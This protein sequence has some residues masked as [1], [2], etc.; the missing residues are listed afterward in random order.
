[1]KNTICFKNIGQLLQVEPGSKVRIRTN[2]AMLVRGGKVLKLVPNTGAKAGGYDKVIDLGGRS[3]MPGLVDCHTHLV[4]AGNRKDEM[5]QRIAGASYMDIL[6]SGGGILNTVRDTRRATEEALYEA[7]LQ[8]MR[9]M[10]VM[11]T[12]AFEI[13]SGYGLD[14]E[15]E[16]KML[17]VGQRLRQ[18]LKV[19]VTLTYLGAHAVPKNM[20]KEE[21]LSFVIEHLAEFRGLADGVDIFCERDVF[22]A[23]DLRRLFLQ[24]KLLGFQLRAH[25]DELSHTG[26]CF[27]A[28]RLGAL[29]CDHL[30]YTSPRDIRAMKL[31]G[32]TAVLLPGVTLFLGGEKR[33]PVHAMLDMGVTL[34]LATDCN[35]GSS[36]TY[37]MQTALYLAVH[38]YRLTPEQA[39][40]AATY[41]SAKALG[42]HKIYGGLLPE[43][44]ADFLV[45]Q[46]DDYRD[47]FYYFGDNFVEKVYL[48]GKQINPK[49]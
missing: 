12:T 3:V 21:Y 8:R 45:L 31:A 7:A 9:R 4:F 10:M 27:E 20:K 33:P 40:S 46:T 30:D 14:L 49:T 35:P 18:A 44:R 15:T 5:V 11:G 43:Q 1:M 29:S 32:T 2:C 19:P 23:H 39:I 22:A 17:R 37:N 38:L 47:I 41:G 24:A 42:G 16:K 48:A 6:K 25:A 34:A 13:K 26:G 28:A 36:P